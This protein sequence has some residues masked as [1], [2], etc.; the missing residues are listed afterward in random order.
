MKSANLSQKILIA[1]LSALFFVCGS[2]LTYFL[3]SLDRKAD[4]FDSTYTETDNA[5]VI[6]ELWHGNKTS[7]SFDSANLKT[8]I[9]MLSNDTNGSIENISTNIN[10][11]A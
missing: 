8:L 7:G 10:N 9:Q 3:I 4:A 11:A 1:V 5:V 2:V 6:D